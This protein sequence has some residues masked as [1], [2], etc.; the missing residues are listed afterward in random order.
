MKRLRV[1][2]LLMRPAN[3][4]TSV[5][6]VLAGIAISGIFLQE[7]LTSATIGNIVLL[8]LATIGLYGGGIVFNDVFDYELD[9]V[10]RPERVIPSGQLSLKEASTLGSSLLAFGI[11]MALLVNITAAWFAIFISISALAYD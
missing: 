7:S 4:V 8:C 2:L 1:Y 11:I 5:A 9:R 3:I 10:E 6:D